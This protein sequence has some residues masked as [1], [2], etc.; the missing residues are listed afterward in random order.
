ME[1]GDVA[2]ITTVVLAGTLTVGALLIAPSAKADPSSGE[3]APAH[4]YSFAVIGNA[5]YGDEAQSRFPEL[6]A[7]VNADPHVRMAQGHR[8]AP[9]G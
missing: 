1:R 6:V 2:P 8:A 3:P 7:K 4:A 9:R 5:P